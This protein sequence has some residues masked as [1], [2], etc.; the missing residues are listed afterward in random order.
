[1]QPLSY[2]INGTI[3]YNTK[4]DSPSKIYFQDC[5]ELM[6]N[7]EEPELV[8]EKLNQIEAKFISSELIWQKI[9]GLFNEPNSTSDFVNI[10][11]MTATVCHYLAKSKHSD[12]V[13][14]VWAERTRNLRIHHLD[15]IH[16]NIVRW[17]AEQIS[18]EDWIFDFDSLFDAWGEKPIFQLYKVLRLKNDESSLALAK[19]ILKKTSHLLI[20]ELSKMGPVR[21]LEILDT[22]TMLQCIDSVQSKKDGFYWLNQLGLIDPFVE[23]IQRD[24]VDPELAAYFLEHLDFLNW[25]RKIGK[26][27]KFSDHFFDLYF[28]LILKSLSSLSNSDK[29]ETSLEKIISS[30]CLF[31]TYPKESN[32]MQMVCEKISGIAVGQKIKPETIYSNWLKLTSQFMAGLVYGLDSSIALSFEKGLPKT[33]DLQTASVIKFIARLAESGETR[34]SAIMMTSKLIQTADKRKLSIPEQLMIPFVRIDLSRSYEGVNEL[35]FAL[36][37]IIS[38]FQKTRRDVQELKELFWILITLLSND[39]NIDFKKFNDRFWDECVALGS[40]LKVWD[41][42]TVRAKIP[43]IEKRMQLVE[44]KNDQNRI[45]GVHHDLEQVLDIISGQMRAANENP[46]LL[47][48]HVIGLILNHLKRYLNIPLTESI[49]SIAEF[50]LSDNFLTFFSDKDHRQRLKPALREMV[51]FLAEIGDPN[52]LQLAL[53]IAEVYHFS[54]ETLW[55]IIFATV[56]KQLD[57]SK[58]FPEDIF[59]ELKIIFK[60]FNRYLKINN[61]NIADDSFDK[62]RCHMFDLDI[63]LFS[64]IRAATVEQIVFLRNLLEIEM[65]KKHFRELVPRIDSYVDLVIQYKKIMPESEP[66]AIYRLYLF[67]TDSHQQAI[68]GIKNFSLID[69]QLKLWSLLKDFMPQG[70]VYQRLSITILSSKA[71][72]KYDPEFEAWIDPL[73]RD[74]RGEVVSNQ[75]IVLDTLCNYVIKGNFHSDRLLKLIKSYLSQPNWTLHKHMVNL[76]NVFIVFCARQKHHPDRELFSDVFKLL[77][78]RLEEADDIEDKAE[79]LTL[80]CSIVISGTLYNSLPSELKN[81]IPDIL[82]KGIVEIVAEDYFVQPGDNCSHMQCI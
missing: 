54:D 15:S 78:S 28:D 71:C 32:K 8:V 63:V 31:K 22:A 44:F 75:A 21:V 12:L 6:R 77:L 7:H 64:K 19:E 38:Y 68:S 57:G 47:K 62:I 10:L 79:L 29:I 41:N 14:G 36:W 61:L 9:E 73:V 46:V 81:S 59:Q 49:K 40:E 26:E 3:H 51:L 69:L 34:I 80:I 33:K 24:Q 45:N 52:K 72:S 27:P 60:S 65:D 55:D 70:P 37:N 13:D 23:F 18:E 74:P 53:K 50:V 35:V 56:S 82:V 43:E 67:A 5:L 58:K 1:M 30:I 16:D 4:K 2:E 17:I 39:K 11:G 20:E 25:L 76:L 48:E 66:E 42:L